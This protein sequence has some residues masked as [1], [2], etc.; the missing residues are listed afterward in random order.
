MSIRF[1]PKPSSELIDPWNM[2]L[3]IHAKW[4][5]YARQ[6][7]PGQLIKH[8]ESTEMQTDDLIKWLIDRGVQ[9]G[10]YQLFDAD[11]GL[12]GTLRIDV[13][14]ALRELLRLINADEIK[15]VLVYQISRLFRDLTGIQ[16]NTF[17]DDCKNHN[18]ILVTAYDGMIFNF[19]NPIHMKMYR[20]LA[21][22]A[23]E[24][25]QQQMGLLQEARLRKAR[26]GF[27][28]SMGKIPS[29]FIVDYE[30]E[31][32][33]FR[34]LIAYADHKE[35][36]LEKFFRRYFSL[37]GDIGALY[38]ELDTMPY[39]FPRFAPWVDKRVVNQWKG[40]EK[41]GGYGI[42]RRGVRSILQNPVY[43]GWWIVEGDII[44]KANHDRII[45]EEEEYLFWYAFNR[46]SSY[47]VDGEE[48]GER[49]ESKRRFFQR[50]SNPQEGLLKDCVTS[51]DASVYVHLKQGREYYAIVPQQQGMYVRGMNEIAAYQVDEPFTT[52]FFDHLRETH[53]LDLYQAWVEKELQQHEAL[54]DTLKKQ[55]R[56]I[57]VSQDG[58]LSEIVAIRA[59]IAATAQTEE[60]KK[61]LE[62]EAD[63]YIQKL[64]NKFNGLEL[65]KKQVAEKLQAEEES[66]RYATIKLYADYQS[67]L[68][69][70]IPVWHKKP[71]AIRK[72]FINLVLT[73]AILTLLTP[74]WIQLDLYWSHPQWEAQR[75]YIPRR[76]GTRPEWTE[77]DKALMREHY[78]TMPK[79]I[80]M[81]LLP[82][83]NWGAIVKMAEQLGISRT[84]STPYP[85]PL[86]LCWED[87][88]F[89]RQEDIPLDTTRPI[90]TPLPWQTLLDRTS[91]LGATS[92]NCIPLPRR[93]TR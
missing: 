28:V 22:T 90:C 13:R 69:K 46:L 83:K 43:L 63:G 87:I 40:R 86:H 44:S 92:P 80:L 72:E 56:Q 65:P 45:S 19:N 32:K 77:E 24:Y 59:H 29:G 34:K 75:L 54:L 36:I 3:P 64:R 78:K 12:S 6:S 33:T 21:E 2:S 89:M 18:C 88:Q 26:K 53:D 48:N 30:K 62:Q 41:N 4:G 42:T 60:E 17:A 58:I 79:E 74:H 11:L 50:C 49:V 14:P 27:Y 71:F 20:F 1:Q 55:L 39:V 67:A 47:R 16:Y 51:P 61:Q 5:I 38:R 93:C 57:D 76:K 84:V 35:V 82:T 31:S 73:E 66:Q 23:A 7:T 91:L 68:S 25:L 70:L 52:L 10:Y 37:N 85:V 81:Q 8:T 15:A 9:V